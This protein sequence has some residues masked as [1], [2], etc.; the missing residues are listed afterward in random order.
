MTSVTSGQQELASRA[1][2]SEDVRERCLAAP[3]ADK[4][5]FA[6]NLLVASYDPAAGIGMWLHLGT[7]PE[8]FGLWEDLLLLSLPDGDVLTMTGYRRTPVEERPAGSLLSFSCIEPFRH[9]RVDFDGLLSR[10]PRA[11]LDGG[12]VR[13]GRRERAALSLDLTGVTPVWDGAHTAS[14]GSMDEQVW[15]SDHYQQAMRVTGTVSV[16]GVVHPLDTTGVRD[17]SR[18]QRGHAMDQWGGHTLIHLLFP[19]GR[20]I[21]VQR[22]YGTSGAPTFD[23]AYTLVDGVMSVAEVVEAPRLTELPGA[24]ELSLTVRSGEDLHHLTG[25]LVTS[26]PVTPQRLGMAVGAD[27]EGPY[28]VLLFGHARWTWDGETSYGLTERSYGARRS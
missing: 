6:E 8:D 3:P 10:T 24:R 1:A 5:M 16:G 11:A 13:D 19:S 4:P 9:W 26:W 28:G 15:A 22:M 25:E 2:S 12:L 21:G 7:W 27:L 20:A 17:H 23:M 14:S 18:G